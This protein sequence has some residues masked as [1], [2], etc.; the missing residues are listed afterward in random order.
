VAASVA[1][2][3]SPGYQLMVSLYTLGSAPLDQQRSEQLEAHR[4][5]AE[6]MAA[7]L[8]E[9][10]LPTEPVV[11]TGDAAD[12]LVKLASEREADLVVTGSRCLHGVERWVLGS[13]ARNVL[14][15]SEAS[16]LVVR[17]PRPTDG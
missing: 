6:W 17:R 3:D 7:A 12:E 14:M 16:V 10:G 13:V 1:P 5:H 4:R 9:V 15:H 11:R 8:S 2:V